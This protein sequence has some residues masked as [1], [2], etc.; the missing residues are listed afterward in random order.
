MTR[1][2]ETP[3]C[4]ECGAQ[5]LILLTFERFDRKGL[6]TLCLECSPLAPRWSKT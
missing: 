6:V 2:R 5:P 3:R 4:A 1:P